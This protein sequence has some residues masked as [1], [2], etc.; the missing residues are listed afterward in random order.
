V[1]IPP[2]EAARAFGRKIPLNLCGGF[3]RSGS[4]RYVTACVDSNV[5]IDYFDG[6][7]AAAEE[8][9]LYEGLVI[10][11]SDTTAHHPVCGCCALRR[12]DPA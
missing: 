8:L 5:L 3:G 10:S 6:I 1:A 2:L 11:R 7:L 9:S 4:K 12:Q